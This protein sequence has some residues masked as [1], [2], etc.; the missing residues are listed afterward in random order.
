MLE[1]CLSLASQEFLGINL[2]SQSDRLF[3]LQIFRMVAFIGS[4]LSHNPAVAVFCVQSDFFK[5][6]HNDL[7]VCPRKL[8]AR[9]CQSILGFLQI[10]N[11]VFY[12]RIPEFLFS[13]NSLDST[14]DYADKNIVSFLIR[15]GY[16]THAVL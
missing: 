12:I 9:S 7:P 15:C 6:T 5:G 16:E 11:K 13:H 1:R 4:R 14:L 3:H 8:Y 2:S 10:I